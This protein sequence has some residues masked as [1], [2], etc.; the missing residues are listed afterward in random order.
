MRPSSES[1]AQTVKII[2][3]ILLLFSAFNHSIAALSSRYNNIV[4]QSFETF[5]STIG[6]LVAD[7]A[8][9][10]PASV[11]VTCIELNTA[12]RYALGLQD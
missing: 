1:N 6:G 2:L 12:S 4:V 10:C 9:V 11:R 7:A 3:G 5:R 8:Y